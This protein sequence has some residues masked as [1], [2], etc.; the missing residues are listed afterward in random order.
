M[1]LILLVMTSAWCS[2]LVQQLEE[3][4]VEVQG[5]AS[6]PIV[7]LVQGHGSAQVASSLNPD[8]AGHFSSAPRR[9]REGCHDLV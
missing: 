7:A 1:W 3:H 6:I 8:L 2:P 5:T 4:I 9:V